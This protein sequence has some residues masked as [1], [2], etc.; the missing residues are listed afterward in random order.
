LKKAKAAT[1]TPMPRASIEA[2]VR[3]K[4]GDRRGPRIARYA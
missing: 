2:A 3:V 1:F 4:P